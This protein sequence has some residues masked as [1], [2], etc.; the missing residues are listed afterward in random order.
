M[1]KRRH[2]RQAKALAYLRSC[3]ARGSATALEIGAAA[4]HG[5]SW[6]HRGGRTPKERIGLSIAVALSRRGVV[7][8]TRDNRFRVIV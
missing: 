7:E 5:E 8:P 3:G 1:S 4:V 2:D 6:A